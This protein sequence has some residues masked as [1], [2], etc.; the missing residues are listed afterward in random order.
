MYIV[1]V[2]LGAESGRVVLGHYDNGKLDL[3]VTHRF[4]NTSV[5]LSGR[6]YWDAPNLFYN[7]LTGLRLAVQKC[8]E[9]KILSVGIDTWG[10]D[11]AVLDSRGQM[12]YLPIH[13]RDSYT[14][15]ISEEIAGII[16]E[17][18]LFN[19]TGLAVWPF[20][21]INQLYALKKEKS[22]AFYSGKTLLFTPDLFN[23]W[24]CGVKANEKSIASTSQCLDISGDSFA[25]DLLED[26][27]LRSSLFAEIVNTGTVLGNISAEIKREIG[28]DYNIKVI[29]TACHDTAAAV[30]ATPFDDPRNSAFL[31]C[32]TWS[33]IGIER[34]EPILSEQARLANF[35]HERGIDDTYR[36]LKNVMGLWIVQQAKISFERR[37]FDFSYEELSKMATQGK[38][39]K[40]IIDPNDLR[41][42]APDDMID[43]VMS[44]CGD[45]G[46]DI[47]KTPEDIMCTIL[48]SLAC[49]YRAAIENIEDMT[50]SKIESLHI[51]GGGSQNEILCQW[52]ANLL[53]RKVTAGPVE[54]TA[55]GN[56]L[57]QMKS[58]GIVK[59]TAELREIVKRS[60]DIIEYKKNGELDKGYKKFK[61]VLSS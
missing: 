38:M 39:F 6:L 49:A 19:R 61:K 33:L 48:M 2:D 57:V 1:A 12:I 17:K 5:A 29:A 35:T 28:V 13:Y 53:D 44:Y 47:P 37:G 21:T 7:I 3:E 25:D 24:L 8:G 59:D 51:I 58:L 36:I 20:N 27:G 23:Y 4:K 16:G 31:S 22:M 30:V 15:G 10:V 18:Q 40:S 14:D 42:Y 11:F 41:F 50:N 9:N 54:G 45:T 52:T 56:I 60:S 26:L 32:G 43:A 34:E 55:A 46:Q